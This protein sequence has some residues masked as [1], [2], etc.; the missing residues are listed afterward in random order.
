[1]AKVCDLNLESLGLT[2]AEP[3]DTT[4]NVNDVATFVEYC[5]KG[6]AD[7]EM[8]FTVQ[9]YSK[10]F[11][12][13]KDMHCI[14]V[15]LAVNNRNETCFYI[16]RRFNKSEDEVIPYFNK[17]ILTQ[18]VVTNIVNG[19]KK[20][21]YCFSENAGLCFIIGQSVYIFDDENGPFII[22]SRLQ[23]DGE[24]ITS[25]QQSDDSATPAE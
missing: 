19:V 24:S 25:A 1:M 10:C 2:L 12:D 3:K 15:Y 5:Q 18:D 16:M 20:I 17:I 6:N 11:C 9:Q 7:S 4:I 22:T 13:S 23:W 21:N 14:N 8:V